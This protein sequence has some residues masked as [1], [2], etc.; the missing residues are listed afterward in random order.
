MIIFDMWILETMILTKEEKMYFMIRKATGK[1]K[2]RVISP[3]KKVAEE[4]MKKLKMHL[5]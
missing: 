4:T 3:F 5:E 1:E 2:P